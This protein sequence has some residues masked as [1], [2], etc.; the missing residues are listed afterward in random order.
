MPVYPYPDVQRA[1][2]VL[3][4]LEQSAN[5]TPGEREDLQ[6]M[7]AYRSSDMPRKW[8]NRLVFYEA[9]ASG[10]VETSSGSWKKL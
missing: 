4:V 8:R 3:L 1:Q 9:R 7:A 10:H 6:K 5:L 2:R